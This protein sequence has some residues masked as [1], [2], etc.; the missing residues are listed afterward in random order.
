MSLITSNS[1]GS[2]VDHVADGR[3]T[4]KLAKEL[5][6]LL[7]ITNLSELEG[8]STLG[9]SSTSDLIDSV[10]NSVEDGIRARLVTRGLTVGDNNDENRLPHLT[11]TS[12]GEDDTVNDLALELTT[13]GCETGEFD[14]AHNLVDLLL[15]ADVVKHTARKVG[16]HE[17]KADPIGI[18]HGAGEGDAAQNELEIVDAL[19]ILFEL[20]RAGVILETL[21]VLLSRPLT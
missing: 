12:G 8:N 6:S 11:T 9:A 18:P 7:V 2:T 17:T 4:I 19:A 21:L 1:L 14:L 3:V 15:I 5:S 10:T 13:H 16:V 20:H